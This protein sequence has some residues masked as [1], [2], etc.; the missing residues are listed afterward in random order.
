MFD[1]INLETVAV[2]LA[3]AYLVLAMK[4]SI[5][6]WYCAFFSTAIYVWIFGDVSLYMESALNIYYMA[7]AVYGYYQWQRGGITQEGVAICRW[8][9]IQ[10]AQIVSLIVLASFVSGYFLSVSTDAKLPYL[11]S[12]TSWASVVTT[13]MVARKVLENWIYWMVINSVSIFLFIDR[14]LYQT[15]AMLTLYLALSV[16]GYFAWR[17]TYLKQNPDSSAA[18]PV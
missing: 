9:A 10:H 14:E 5:L 15:A 17:K 8:S 18:S 6:C 13:L 3:V 11:D 4:E 16:I 1:W 7:M 12:F 2:A